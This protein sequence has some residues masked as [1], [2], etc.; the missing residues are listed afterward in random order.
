MRRVRILTVMVLLVAS[1]G[2]RA[3]SDGAGTTT[4]SSTTPVVTLPGGE[5]ELC[6]LATEALPG[7]VDE[8][9]TNE[10]LSRSLAQRAELLKTVAQSTNG[11]LADALN[12]SSEAM[13]QLATAV[14]AD[15]NPD[16]LNG[17]IAELQ[18]DTA[19][20]AAQ[21]VIDKAVAGQCGSESE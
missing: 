4:K 10:S 20:V 21:E 6:K 18:N 5:V 8:P 2:D 12:A 1:C 9:A 11:D 14:A 15:A 16:A 3:D 13:S 17:L 7:A 19:F